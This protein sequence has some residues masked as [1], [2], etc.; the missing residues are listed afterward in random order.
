ML[1]STLYLLLP[2]LLTYRVE[3]LLALGRLDQQYATTVHCGNLSLL[4]LL[5]VLALRPQCSQLGLLSS[6]LVCCS[7]IVLLLK[8]VSYIQ[9]RAKRRQ[10]CHQDTPGLA[11]I[12]YFWL[13]PTLCYTPLPPSPHS[14]PR[15]SFLLLR[16]LELCVC[17]AGSWEGIRLLAIVTPQLLRAAE[18]GSYL[19]VLER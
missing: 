9:V 5:P 8:L 19:L 10:N 7:H 15:P 3:L 6:T 13:C 18:Q 4:L 16:L 12:L 1:V 14:S 17:G 2:L 11:D